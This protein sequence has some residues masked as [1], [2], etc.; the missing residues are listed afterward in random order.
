VLSIPILGDFNVVSLEEP[1]APERYL[2]AIKLCEAPIE[3]MCIIQSATSGRERRLLG[4]H[5]QLGRLPRL[6]GK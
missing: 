3:L 2:E 4:V 6:G 5:E 1:F